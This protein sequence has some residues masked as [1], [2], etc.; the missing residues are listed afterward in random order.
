MSKKTEDLKVLS[1]SSLEII[2]A[3]KES[4]ILE[5]ALAIGGIAAEGSKAFK[6]IHAT[7]VAIRQYRHKSFMSSAWKE[8]EKG[9]MGSEE[10]AEKINEFNS[11]VEGQEFTFQIFQKALESETNWGASIV[12]LL[13]GRAVSEKR[14]LTR[15]EK[16]FCSAAKDLDNDEIQLLIDAQK[17]FEILVRRSERLKNVAERSPD[18]KSVFLSFIQIKDAMAI[19]IES[20]VEHLGRN[21]AWYHQRELLPVFKKFKALGLLDN[22]QIIDGSNVNTI[23]D[24]TYRPNDLTVAFV[25][26]A[27]KCRV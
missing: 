1:E 2:K 25:E 7:W 10:V 15:N 14:K 16:T 22:G 26:I 21:P 6:L 11:T 12:G 8:L 24:Q 4:E 13:W 20:L 23:P 3:L 19:S 9:S 27:E 5:N 18:G 17:G